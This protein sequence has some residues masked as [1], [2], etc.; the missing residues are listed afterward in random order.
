MEIRFSHVSGLGLNDLSFVIPKGEITGIYGDKGKELLTLLSL[1][2]ESKGII[3]F[4]KIRKLKRNSYLFR[5]DIGLVRERF[6]KQFA[7]DGVYEY[8]VYYIRYHKIKVKDVTKKIKDAVKLVGLSVAILERKFSTL[9]YSEE[10]LL[11]L[12]LA[13]L[14]NPK[15][16]LLEEPFRGYDINNK[17]RVCR[18][19][20][21][22][23]EKYQ[24]TIVIYSSDPNTL[25]QY[26]TNLIV[27]N[28]D[29]VVLEGKSR[30][31]FFE[32]DFF[33]SKTL[34]RP[35]IVAFIRLVKE[36]TG[37]DL[38][39]RADVKDVI[40]DVYWNAR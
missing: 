10:K 32:S 11:S 25:Y 39:R 28:K 36:K 22:L 7:I 26:T 2:E 23:Q 20:Y 24:K 35:E 38:P 40:K 3:Y 37:I 8:F 19:L 12:A 14:S 33:S 6:E 13:L 31:L 27:L 5:K 29:K 16:L 21:K 34:E 15:V 4:N 30:D 18:I 17:K 9:T 1:Q